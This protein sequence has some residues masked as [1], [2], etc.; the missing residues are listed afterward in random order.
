MHHHILLVLVTIGIL[1]LASQWLAW[2][3]RVPAVLFLLVG[4]VVLGPATGVLQPDDMFG[5]LLFPFISLAVSVILFEGSLT[6]NFTE[7]KGHG[8]VVRRLIT[9]GVAIAM[10]SVALFAHYIIGASWQLALLFGA[11]MTVTGPTVIMPMLQAVRPTRN[12]ANILRWEGILVDPV[13][14]ILAVLTFSAILASQSASTLSGVALLLLRLVFC[15]V[16]VGAAAGYLWTVALRRY[17]IPSYLQNVA[18]LLIVF[19]VYALADVLAGESGLLAVTVMG[20]WLGNARGVHIDEILDFKES[21]SILLI[22]GLFILLAA[23]VDFAQ[24]QT[25][26]WSALL[27]MLAIQFIVRPVQVLLCSLGSDLSWR[28]RALIAWIGPRGIVAAAISAV[29][30]LRLEDMGI[31]DADLL[32]PLAFVVIV[33]TVVLQSLTAGKLAQLLQVAMPEP[34]GVLFVGANSLTTALARTLH[35]NNFT[36]RVSHSNWEGLRPA[37]MA[38]IDTFYGNPMSD[39]AER[40]LDLSGIG[41]LFAMSRNPDFNHLACAHFSSDFGRQGVYELPVSLEAVSATEEKHLPAEGMRGRRLFGDDISLSKL[42]SLMS[43]GAEI[44]TTSLSENFS[45]D[46][47]LKHAKGRR[48]PLVA[49]NDKGKLVA[50]TAG[51]KWQPGAGWTIASL[52]LDDEPAQKS[53][54]VAQSQ[55]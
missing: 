33:G 29:F 6:L 51:D 8:M 53:A 4:G 5:D 42:L 2:R 24:L 36:V 47:F 55:G 48:I 26:G 3:L 10:F 49:W 46:D 9:F 25:V 35:E 34:E 19:A 28:E 15:G 37:R 21:L 39:R 32:V 16:L 43:R 22:S 13:G 17:L 18:T 45:F 14:A 44:K 38:G 23:R 7:I 50:F 40:M 41:K 31:A 11:I 30:A 52:C 12:I 20:M 54:E 1:S 27:V